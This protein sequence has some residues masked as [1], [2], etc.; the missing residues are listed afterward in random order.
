MQIQGTSGRQVATV[1]GYN[2]LAGKIE[3][4]ANEVQQAKGAI[5]SSKS[6]V[7]SLLADAKVSLVRSDGP[8]SRCILAQGPNSDS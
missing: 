3:A 2:K 5:K 4:L 1:T 6:T 8:L 7:D